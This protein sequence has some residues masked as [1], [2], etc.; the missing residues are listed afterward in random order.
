M[1]SEHPFPDPHHNPHLIAKSARS[2]SHPHLSA[3]PGKQRIFAPK[4]R[5]HRDPH[6]IRIS[7]SLPHLHFGCGWDGALGNVDQTGGNVRK[8][9]T[10]KTKQNIVLGGSLSGKRSALGPVLQFWRKSEHQT[11][12]CHLGLL[13]SQGRIFYPNPYRDEH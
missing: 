8:N 6:L 3:K 1:K 2:A 7:V 10:F 9:H 5:P 4:S 12:S 11:C 13:C